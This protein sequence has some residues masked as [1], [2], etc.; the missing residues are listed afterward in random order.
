MQ[1]NSIDIP[2]GKYGVVGCDG[3]TGIVINIDGSQFNSLRQDFPVLLFSKIDEA[4]AYISET[5]SNNDKLEFVIY[6][7]NNK[8]INVFEALS[9]RRTMDPNRFY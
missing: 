3:A 1:K 8:H 9:G 5:Q 2:K 4:I 7:D 6:D